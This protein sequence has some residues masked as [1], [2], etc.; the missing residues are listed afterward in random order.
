M[1]NR[2]DVY[3][4]TLR[5]STY[6]D[7]LKSRVSKFRE[8]CQTTG[9]VNRWALS[10][11][12]NYGMQ[13]DGKC[14]WRVTNAGDAGEL[15][16]MKVNEYASYIRH[17]LTLAVQQRPAGIAKAINMD[18]KTL[19]NARLGSQLVEYYFSDPSHNFEQ[20]YVQALLLTLLSAEAYIVQDWNPNAGRELRPDE[21]GKPM[22][23]G[24]LEQCLYPV[25]NAARDWQHPDSKVPWYIFSKR[26]NKWDLA[27]TPGFEPF[28]DEIIAQSAGTAVTKP[29]FSDDLG[30]SS[31]YVEE[32]RFICFPCPSVPEGRYTR[33]TGDTIFL[34]VAYPYPCK[35]VHRVTEQDMIES[36]HGHTANYDLLG[37]EQVTDC[38]DS[39][40]LN[41]LSTFGIA[42]IVGPKGGTGGAGVFHKDLGKGLRYLEM[43]PA[44]A[45]AIKVLDLCRNPKEIFEFRQII[46]AKKG[47]LS[48]INSILRGDPQGALK[49]ASGSAMALLQSQALVYNSGV[50]QSFYKLLSSAGTGIIE[51]CREYA[52]EPRLVK[53][54]GKANAKAIKEFKYDSDTLKAVSTIVFE[55]INPVLQTAAGK[56]TVAE[57]LLKNN[58]CSSPKR[59]I[60]VLTTGNLQSLIGD[61]VAM[62]D[63]I[64]EENEYLSEG[65]PVEV[66][67][68]ENHEGHI[69]AH[70]AV[71]YSPNAKEDPQ[72]VETGTEHIQKHVDT[73]MWLS[74]NNPALLIATGQKVLP[75]GQPGMPG[76]PGMPQ[77]MPG[78]A[79]GPPNPG[80][81]ANPESSG[82]L[83]NQPSLPKPPVD[84][85]SGEDAVVAPNTAV[86]RAA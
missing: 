86:R 45:A 56:L 2:S 9:L 71:F 21:T 24:D 53:L 16:Q 84:P 48:G 7:E 38:L 25:W 70:S 30:D 19:R 13:P 49:G 69:M 10:L 77:G 27:A 60:E 57:N 4:A 81:E 40:T 1:G 63:A 72:T 18:I 29:F 80:Q 51:I 74:I 22:Q 83:D 12:N 14:S 41:N 68:T 59:Y 5:D 79:G 64:I 44:Q 58:M 47:E 54:S 62:Q 65:K 61:D 33:F 43:E 3:F 15:V 82:P 52:D 73:W 6:I 50:Q 32:H 34:D 75:V 26:T 76:A 31:D 8:R 66:L 42:T 35:N 55:A 11:G 23:I 67:L 39:I 28:G 46:S 78:Q 85:S 20:D 37:L 36:S 17:E